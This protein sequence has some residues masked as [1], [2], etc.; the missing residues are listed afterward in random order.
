M[1]QL[2]RVREFSLLSSI[3]VLG[4]EGHM[5]LAVILFTFSVL[6]PLGKLLAVLAATTRIIPPVE[7]VRER[8]YRVVVFLGKYSMLDIFVAALFVVCLKVE[9]VAAVRLSPGAL[10][11]CVAILLSMAAGQT[12]VVGGSGENDGESGMKDEQGHG[13]IEPIAEKAVR[14]R[15]E[16]GRGMKRPWLFRVVWA[17]AALALLGGGLLAMNPPDATITRIFVQKDKE[18]MP[19]V[20]EVFDSPD[21]YVEIRTKDGELRKSAVYEDRLIGNGIYW[22]IEPILLARIDEVTLYDENFIGDT[23]LERITVLGRRNQ[24]QKYSITLEGAMPLM[25]ILG[26][27]LAGLGGA[28]LV[29]LGIGILRRYAV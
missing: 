1:E 14:R 15:E 2:G 28:V 7:H 10:L 5:F 8:I 26:L 9:G 29:W 21:Y 25:K 20:S 12:M 6:F 13:A 11:F 3:A 17:M 22:D 27:V 19:S 4:R 18:F 16:S 24:G 23:P